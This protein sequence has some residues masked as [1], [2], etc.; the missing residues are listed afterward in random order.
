MVASHEKLQFSEIIFTKLLENNMFNYV[1]YM[2]SKIYRIIFG[3]KLPR[4]LPEMQAC[5]QLS[6][7]Y[8]VGDWFLS[9]N[10]TVIILYG[11]KHKPYVLPGFLTLRVFYLEFLRQKL[12]VEDNNFL[13]FKQATDIKYPFTLGPFTVKNKNAAIYIEKLLKDMGFE[14]DMAIE[15]DSLNIISKRRTDHRIKALDHQVIEGMS[16]R[17]NWFDYKETKEIIPDSQ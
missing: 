13:L 7:E 4:V 12:I 11:F 17:A 1:N 9:K 3:E 14:T 8:A 5:M 15:Y 10:S 16:D 6:A 2:L